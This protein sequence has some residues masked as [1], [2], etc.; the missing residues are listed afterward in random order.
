MKNLCFQNLADGDHL[1]KNLVR[2]WCPLKLVFMSERLVASH[3]ELEVWR[4]EFAP[5]LDEF[6]IWRFIESGIHF[7]KVERFR[8]S[9]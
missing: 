4:H 9:Y 3:G 8:V 6:D 1:L 2:F 5:R 7:Y